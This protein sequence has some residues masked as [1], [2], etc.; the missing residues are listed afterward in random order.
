ME[1]E[2][3]P[4]TGLDVSQAHAERRGELLGALKGKL[5][6]GAYDVL[7]NGHEDAI[8]IG[9]GQHQFTHRVTRDEA[10]RIE[11]ADWSS[12]EDQTMEAL[13]G[14]IIRDLDA[15]GFDLRRDRLDITVSLRREA[16]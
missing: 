1:T 8:I 10:E 16:A 4:G 6:E 2:R 14:R 9:D 13:L 5:S 12:G 7:R 3:R 11:R 15:A